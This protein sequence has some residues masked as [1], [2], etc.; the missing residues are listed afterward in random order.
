MSKQDL[1]DLEIKKR[2]LRD[3]Y[4]KSLLSKKEFCKELGCSVASL[5]RLRRT[6]EELGL[7]KF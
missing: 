2:E 7:A 6:S 5:D 3:E 4:G 1:S